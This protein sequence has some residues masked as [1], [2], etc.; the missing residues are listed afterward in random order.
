MGRPW[1]L[2]VAHLG[3][4]DYSNEAYLHEALSTP[5][6]IDPDI[7]ITELSID[8]TDVYTLAN[9][10]RLG[11]FKQIRVIAAAN[12]PVGSVTGL[13][14][15]GVTAATTIA[16]LSTVDDMVQLVSTRV[17]NVYRWKVLHHVGCTFS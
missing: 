6:S 13:F 15:N 10:T 12:T 4:G 8:G 7:P 1:P 16:S 17:S 5:G 3:G 14:T 2:N 11:Q 9:P